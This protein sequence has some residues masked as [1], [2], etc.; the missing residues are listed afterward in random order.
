VEAS[1]MA[2]E[3]DDK[4]L[5]ES[6]GEQEGEDNVDFKKL[7]TTE[8]VIAIQNKKTGEDKFFRALLD[9][10]TTR[11]LGTSEAVRRSGVQEQENLH[12]HT[13]R[14][15]MGTF[16]TET[17]VTIR[18]H[19]LMELSSRRELSKLHVQVVRGSLGDYDFVFGR[20]YLTRYGIDLRFSNRTIEWDG[21]TMEMHDPGYWTKE[22][23]TEVAEA[24][25]EADGMFACTRQILE[26]QYEKQSIEVVAA[27]QK[28]L[29]AIQQ[30]QLENTLREHE[31]LFSGTLGEWPEVEVDVHLVHG[32]QPYRCR[33]PFRIPH[34]YIDTLKHEV[35]RLVGIGVLE[36]VHE[37][38][39]WAAPSFIIPKKDGRVRFIT[40]FRKLNGMVRRTPW[41]M[42]HISD[43]IED[44]GRYTYVT[45]L[46]LSM[47]YYHFKLSDELSK[48]CSFMLPFGMYRYKRLPMGLKISPDFF[49]QRMWELFGDLPFVKCYLDDIA[50]VTNG[51]CEDHL[52]KLK[53]VLQ[54]L[55]SKGLQINAAKSFCAAQEV[56]YLGYILTPTGVKPQYKKVKAIRNMAAPKNRKQLRSFIGLVNFYRYMWRHRSQA[57]EPLTR[58]T[59]GKGKLVWTAEQQKAFDEI[60]RIVSKEVLLSFPDY[61]KEFHLYT[62]A[63][64][65]QLGA[66]LV[67][68]DRPIAFFSKKLNFSQKKYSVG[69]K[70][71][72]SVVETLQ[73]FRNIV[74]VHTDHKNLTYDTAVYK[75]SRV[76]RWRLA[77]EEFIPTLHFVDG[78]KNVVADALSRLP[79][80]DNDEDGMSVDEIFE[81]RQDFTTPVNFLRILTE[82]KKDALVQKLQR[83]TPERLS[84]VFDDVGGRQ[85]ETAIALLDPITN[86]K[87]LLCQRHYGHSCY[88]GT[89]PYW[90]I[91]V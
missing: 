63:S 19:R 76:M 6:E 22:K 69:E 58:L 14:T 20:D 45:T 9:T 46:D 34:I 47:G 30:K 89:T 84:T 2:A 75:N 17:K 80:D 88:N 68:A 32:A 5:D 52:T 16:A 25:G 38:S 71:M 35:E 15:A 54:R 1:F 85:E 51:S 77:I 59:G 43:L 78:E 90:S 31:V 83:E 66:V 11:T 29:T 41:P 44:I 62:D 55:Q 91:L 82:Q 49:Q 56:E 13:Y 8:I 21:I 4:E 72:L 10:G 27:S 67:Q 64:E 50:I 26:S 86:T 53:V 74:L 3:E 73:Q 48:M 40:D 7:P 57:M 33:K 60:K 28:H 24:V 65:S 70:E 12:R 23:M 61:S 18:R 39:D 87:R 42:P 36:P 37:E 79:F 81:V